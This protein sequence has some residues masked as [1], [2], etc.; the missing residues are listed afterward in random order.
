MQTGSGTKQ[1]QE[2]L[3]K[4]ITR[5]LKWGQA[6]VAEKNVVWQINYDFEI[7]LRKIHCIFSDIAKD[8]CCIFNIPTSA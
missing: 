2:I 5:K 7:K 3:I 6:R 8:E 1:K 4:S